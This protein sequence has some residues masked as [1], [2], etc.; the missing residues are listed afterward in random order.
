MPVKLN[1]IHKHEP[2]TCAA[3]GM[4]GARVFLFAFPRGSISTL[5]QVVL[6]LPRPGATDSRF[7]RGTAVSAVHSERAFQLGFV[8]RNPVR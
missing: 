6:N 3:I 4:A 8:E 5:M 2:L 7:R 1:L